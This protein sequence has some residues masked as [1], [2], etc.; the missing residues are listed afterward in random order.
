MSRLQRVI[1]PGALIHVIS[2]FLNGKHLIQAA[3][4]RQ[5]YVRRLGESLLD[6]DWRAV[7][8]GIM[9]THTH[10]G[11]VAGLTPFEILFR[12][13]HSG[14]ARWLN[15]RQH[16][17]GPVFA[18]RPDTI[19]VDLADAARFI[20]YVH[21]NPVRAGV[22]TYASASGWTSHR[23][24]LEREAALP[25]LDTTLGLQLCGLEGTVDDRSVFD[26]MV[27]DRTGEQE[28]WLCG[29]QLADHRR[30]AR[31]QGGTTIELGYP[32]VSLRRREAVY[33]ILTAE[34]VPLRPDW[35][36]DVMEVLQAASR[37]VG[38]TVQEMR[39]STRR[40]VVSRAR[41]LAVLI[42]RDYLGC[43]LRGI[44]VQL[45]ITPQSACGLA[46]RCDESLHDIARALAQDIAAPSSVA[47]V[48]FKDDVSGAANTNKLA[49][50]PTCPRLA[51]SDEV[52]PQRDRDGD[53][54]A[55]EDPEQG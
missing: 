1:R 9:S 33:P 54:C 36:G 8:F 20:S 31:E 2:R 49:P 32:R 5:E 14:F 40:R 55:E 46:Q 24:Y 18:D 27:N 29:R 48:V 10:S 45:G 51:Q 23:I 25:W 35:S 34:G 50:S 11:L 21:N 43:S 3:V 22:V 12:R 16:R 30:A 52:D 4:E 47:Q 19:E 44:A 13:V 26:S 37:Q 28:P 42:Y 7:S 38:V 41:K 39:S 6:S 53:G 17:L 15:K